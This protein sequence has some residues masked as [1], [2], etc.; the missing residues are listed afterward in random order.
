MAD[1]VL[2]LHDVAVSYGRERRVLE[3]DRLAV[4]R[5]ERVALIGP[6]GSGKTTLLRLANGYVRPE[7]GA[8]D[9]FG[10]RLESHGSGRQ[11]SLR[12]R[13]GFVFQ[14][15]NLVERATVFENVLSGRLGK[16]GTL[17]SLVGRFGSHHRRATMEAIEEVG[18]REQ[19]WQRADTLSGGQQQR[20][21]VARVVAQEAELILADE[22]VSNLDP[23]LAEDVLELLQEVAEHHR[24]TL[25]CSLH[26][27]DLARRFAERI[28]GLRAG[29]VVWDGAAEAL[30]EGAIVT[31]YGQEDPESSRPARRSAS[32]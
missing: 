15:F 9:L 28:V 19:T 8:V 1:T 31:I 30:D 16:M 29:R 10:E 32:R 20:V 22:P 24:A 11:R 7:R 17:A 4:A 25:V 21:G 5:G 18:L 26:Q 2:A 6:S 14:G 3:I 27:P 23:R 13:V 12:R